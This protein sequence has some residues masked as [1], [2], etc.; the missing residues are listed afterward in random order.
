MEE[1]K[2]K[3]IDL[4]MTS[5]TVK[6]KRRYL[7]TKWRVDD[8]MHMPYYTKVKRTIIRNMKYV[9]PPKDYIFYNES[10]F[11]GFVHTIEPDG[12]K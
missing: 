3:E 5:V 1:I 2:I 9:E 8:G 6:A 10:V 4:K 7:K 12:K 11:A